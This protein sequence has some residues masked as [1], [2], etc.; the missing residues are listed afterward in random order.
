MYI[1][2]VKNIPYIIMMYVLILLFP[3][4]RRMYVKIFN[5]NI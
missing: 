1:Y 4:L 5:K 3:V 2:P